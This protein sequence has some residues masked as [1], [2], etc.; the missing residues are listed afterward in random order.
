MSINAGRNSSYQDEGESHLSPIRDV[1]GFV[2]NNNNGSGSSVGSSWAPGQSTQR[3]S[4][5]GS[6]SE[7]IVPSSGRRTAESSEEHPLSFQDRVVQAAEATGSSALFGTLELL[8][9]AGGATLSTT[10][11]IISPS[12]QVTRNVILPA[13]WSTLSDYVAFISPQRLKDWFRIIRS[14]LYHFITVLKNTHKGILFRQRVASIGADVMDCLSS[15]ASRQVIVDGMA[16]MIKLAE[17]LHTPETSTFLDQMAVFSSRLVDAAASGRNKQLLKDTKEAVW[18]FCQLASDPS[19]TLALAEVT[20]CLCHALEMEEAIHRTQS[21]P[22]HLA[23]QRRY[24]RNR[25]QRQTYVDPDMMQDPDTTVE[26]VIL[27]SLG[28]ASEGDNGSLSSNVDFERIPIEMRTIATDSEM[29]LQPLDDRKN[30]GRDAV[31]TEYLHR[32]ISQRAATRERQKLLRTTVTTTASYEIPV[33]QS[34]VSAQLE[35]E[36][37]DDVED[38]IG[39]EDLIVQTVNEDDDDEHDDNDPLAIRRQS[40]MKQSNISKQKVQDSYGGC[41]ESQE[42]DGSQD[43]KESPASASPPLLTIDGEDA[44]SRFFRS[45]DELMDKKRTDALQFVLKSPDNDKVGAW[46]PKAAA[47]AGAGNE[48]GQDTLKQRMRNKQSYRSGIGVG[49]QTITNGWKQSSKDMGKDNFLTIL[50]VA[51]I[52]FLALTWFV[53]GFYGLYV[54]IFGPP[55]SG[56]LKLGSILSMLKPSPASN[57]V[58]IRVVREVVHLLPDGTVLEKLSDSSPLENLENIAECIAASVK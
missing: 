47:A 32:Q 48:R 26:Q 12:I 30:D 27:S 49:R 36:F 1:S 44:A 19:T 50:F 15:D 41:E 55:K 35:E 18:A 31:D 39:P 57:E 21:I 43:D 3:A 6:R 40:T 51:C 52:G 10:G 4:R 45:L 20:A 23:S 58:V 14:S 13:L 53:L 54:I 9:L 11:K 33:I 8:K 16:S 28:G 22:K 56:V 38:L 46:Y 42:F 25:F 7:P 37:E 17:A 24:E 5:R 29:D 2:D 34:K